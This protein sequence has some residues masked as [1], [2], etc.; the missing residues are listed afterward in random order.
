MKDFNDNEWLVDELANLLN[1]TAEAH[2]K[3]FVAINY[4]IGWCYEKY[5]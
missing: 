3:A 5:E 2:H 4:A 1:E